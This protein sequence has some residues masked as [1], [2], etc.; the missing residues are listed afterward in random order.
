MKLLGGVV[1][2]CAIALLSTAPAFGSHERPGSASPTSV[3]LVPTFTQC[4]APNT[5]HTPPIS[6]FGG[7]CTPT[8]PRSSLLT[9]SN[10]GP[11]SGRVKYTVFCTNGAAPPCSAAGD[12]EDVAVMLALNDV[13]CRVALGPAFCE[14]D[15]DYL[16]EVAVSVP[17]RV[18]DHASGNPP[19]DCANPAGSPPCI[20]AT[21][22]DFPL[23]MV[24]GC[25]PNASVDLGSTCN[26]NTTLDAFNPGMVVERQRAVYEA[27]SIVVLDLGPDGGLG[28][29]CP[30]LCGTG[31]E[32]PFM[33]QGWFAP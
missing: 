30:P 6:D 1:V 14:T 13:R 29:S 10:F 19:A 21:V 8:T 18:T 16:R 27:G 31:D 7:A 3:A 4:A 9:I 11:G 33:A 25:L 22:E 17:V 20:A 28:V 32:R 26:L 2:A 23:V 12:Q 24:T 15:G 5:A